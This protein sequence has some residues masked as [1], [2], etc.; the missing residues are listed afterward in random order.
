MHDRRS[1]LPLT[2]CTTHQVCMG[3]YMADNCPMTAL[4]LQRP[5]L[6][7]WSKSLAFAFMGL[8]ISAWMTLCTALQLANAM[9]QWLSTTLCGSSR[10]ARRCSLCWRSFPRGQK[11]TC[12]PCWL[13]GLSS[14]R[15]CCIARASRSNT[16]LAVSSSCHSFTCMHM[17]TCKPVSRVVMYL[18]AANQHVKHGSGWQRCE[19]QVIQCL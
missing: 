8:G 7:T 13:S 5:N 10:T 15:T 2:E 9:Q 19:C 16:Q 14:T 1:Q 3:H 11:A 17:G 18:K 4:M 12:P 6:D